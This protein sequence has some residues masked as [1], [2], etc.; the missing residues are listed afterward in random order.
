MTA[1][2]TLELILGSKT[3]HDR[4]NTNLSKL[5]LDIPLHCPE[6][7]ELHSNVGT[8]GT[9]ETIPGVVV[10]FRCRECGGT[11][12]PSKIPFWRRKM[13]EIIWKLAQLVVQNQVTVNWLAEQH[14]VPET[15]LRTL[16]TEL[17]QLLAQNYRVA[18]EIQDRFQ[19]TSDPFS[20]DLKVLFYDE[21]FLKLLGGTGFLIFTL[22]HEGNPLTVQV[23]P[24]RDAATIYKHLR[25]AVDQLGGVDLIIGDGA[26]ALVAAT[27]ALRLP[28]TLVQ[29]IHSGK[30]KRARIRHYQPIPNRKAMWETMIELH[31]GSLLPNVESIMTVKRKKIYPKDYSSPSPS[32]PGQQASLQRDKHLIE[33]IGILTPEEGGQKKKSPKK[34]Q[35]QLLKG[36]Q[37]VVTT[38]RGLNEFE[39]SYLSG[40]PETHDLSCPSLLEI[41]SLLTRVQSVLPHQFITSN[42]AEVF[43]ALFDRFNHFWGQKNLFQANQ[44]TLAW[45]VMT[46]FPIGA[47]LLIQHH[48]WR[49][50]YRLL[51]HFWYL[52]ISGVNF[53]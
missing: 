34:T 18:Q 17:K 36:H 37:I 10:R 22:N 30:G 29:Q 51:K 46:F 43:N 26:T 33:R 32:L 25:T 48:N 1:I 3:L 44:D 38:G 4:P 12:N 40:K 13:T 49:L 15:T 2:A 6:C 39:L 27:K 50:P 52:M 41:G 20:T 23:E 9:Y 24:K 42:R 53:S 31:T 47:R 14:K 28:V 11:F 45:A 8:W 35:P 16:L 5:A 21:G 19:A 7:A